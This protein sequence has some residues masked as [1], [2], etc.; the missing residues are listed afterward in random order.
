MSEV[1][2]VGVTK[3]HDG[4]RGAAALTALDLRIGRGELVALVGPSGSGKSTAL[5]ILAGVDAPSA[6]Q[7]LFDGVD[8]TATTLTQRDVAAVF[9]SATPHSHLT[10]FEN[11]A[12]ALR[13]RHQA[14]ATIAAR[15]HEVAR[16]LGID[17]LLDRWPRTLSGGQRQR[18]AIGRALVVRP[19]VFLFDEALANLDARSRVEVRRQLRR[20]HDAAGA[21]TL[22]VTHDL[23]DAAAVADR[24]VV[25]HDGAVDRD[26]RL[27]TAKEMIRCP[28]P[29]LR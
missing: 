15:I 25:L 3:R 19:R 29:S 17:D 5:R 27:T 22:Y 24:I 8:V 4:R 16:D 14:E 18:V 26:L 12:F 23:L 6:G 2:L 10:V 13:Q 20:A 1:C 28:A 21:A 7:V 11:L 9:Q